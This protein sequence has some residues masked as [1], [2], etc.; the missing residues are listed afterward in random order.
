MKY[1]AR[2]LFLLS[3]FVASTMN[4]VSAEENSVKDQLMPPKSHV[5]SAGGIATANYPATSV[6][7]QLT[8]VSDH[9]YYANGLPGAATENEGFISNAG[10]IITDQGVVL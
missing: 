2:K 7:M 9:V 6:D 5:D 4:I 1:I 3:T 10:V 8:K